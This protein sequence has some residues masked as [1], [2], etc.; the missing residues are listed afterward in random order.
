M[1][2]ILAYTSP[3]RGHLFPMTPLLLELRDRG[4]QVHVRTLG[5]QTELMRSLG[6]AA[7]PLDPRIEA[8]IMKDYTASGPKGT[9][10]RGGGV[11]RPRKL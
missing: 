6:L 8:E 10:G 9:G 7:E 4:H 3:A 11:R 2:T 5:S 1:S